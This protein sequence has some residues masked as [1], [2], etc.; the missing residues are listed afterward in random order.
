LKFEELKSSDKKS[1]QLLVSE[2]LKRKTRNAE[3][4]TRNAE[5]G[6]RNAERRTR[7]VER[8]TR[9][10]PDPDIDFLSGITNLFGF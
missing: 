8:G 4:R 9:V 1:M 6:T 7:N 2:I 3:R 5:H 10:S